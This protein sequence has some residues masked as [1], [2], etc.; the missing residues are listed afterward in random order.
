MRKTGASQ[1][2]PDSKARHDGFTL[3][4]LLVV[5]LI[6]GILA[7][8]AVPVFL[9]QRSKGYDAQAKSDLRNLANFEEVYLND[10]DSY[11]TIAQIRAAEPT[12]SASPGVTL[13]VVRYDGVKGYC[14]SAKHAASPDTWYYDSQSG[15]L[16]PKG[17]SSCPV[18]T[19]GTP[20]DTIP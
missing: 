14:L 16:Q 10:A 12:L 8:I 7:A 15:G 4:E 19:S 11:G 2:T 20:G 6:I 17:T 13:S 5:I 3:V 1:L 9:N 18:T